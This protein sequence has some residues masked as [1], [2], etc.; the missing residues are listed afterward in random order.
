[1][2]VFHPET[3]PV[4]LVK[5]L[6]FLPNNFVILTAKMYS[7]S[8]TSSLIPLTEAYKCI[9]IPSHKDPAHQTK[10]GPAFNLFCLYL[11]AS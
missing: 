2:Q 6:I 7:L 9:S 8:P 4:C 11:H 1:M 5:Y 10:S 3:F